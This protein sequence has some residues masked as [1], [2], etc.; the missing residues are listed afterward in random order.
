VSVKYQRIKKADEAL[1]TPLRWLTRT[2]SSITLSVTLLTFVC[3]Y[4]LFASVPIG[5]IVAGAVYLL[6]VVGGLGLGG[7]IAVQALRRELLKNTG[8]AARSVI[9]VLAVV[10]GAAASWFG[11]VAAYEAMANHPWF[12]RHSATVIYRLPGIE[13]TEL[14]FYSWWP[15]RLVLVLFVVNMVWAT[16]R[17]IE[18][19]WL[20]IGVLTVHT[21]IVVMALGS[22]FYG[23]LKVEGDTILFRQDL[24]GPIEGVFYDAVEPAIYFRYRSA[25]AMAPVPEL[26]RYNDYP[27]GEL[28]LELTSASNS[29]D[30]LGEMIRA[31]VVGYYAYADLHQHWEDADAS[32]LTPQQRNPLVEVALGTRDQAV[33]AWQEPLIA[34]VPS[35]RVLRQPDWAMEV[36]GD[37]SDR[38]LRDLM[39]DVDAPH[40]LVVELPALDDNGE[41]DLDQPPVYREAFAIQQGQTIEVPEHDLT[42]TAEAIG[43]YGI[44][45]VTPGYQGASDTRI[46]ATVTW[47]GKTF[48]RIVMHRYPERSQDFVP[49]PD[50]PS[51]GPMGERQDPDP[52][53]HLAYLDNSSTQFRLILDPDDPDKLRLLARVPGAVPLAGELPPSSRKFPLVN[54]EQGAVWMHLTR[55]IPHAVEKWEPHPVPREQRDP[56]EEG[57]F[58]HALVGVEISTTTPEG[59]PWRQTLWLPHMRYPKYPDGQNRFWP[60]SVPGIGALEV[61]F[62]RT[63]RDLPFRLQLVGFDMIPYPGS[64]IPNDYVS[65]LAVIPETQPGENR[66]RQFIQ[67]KTR[68]N[69]PLYVE[70]YKLSQVGWDPG[71]KTAPNHEATDDQ[72]RLVNQQRFS[73]IGVGNNPG[74]AMIWT[75][76]ILTSLGIPW[77]LWVKPMIV[78]RKATKLREQLQREKA[79]GDFTTEHATDAEPEQHDHTKAPEP[80]KV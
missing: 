30:F 65:T 25:M 73:I 32:G 10:I 49:R 22:I 47:Q 29:R 27:A 46:Q 21:G 19:R 18:F 38:R 66:D 78:R 70:G 14:Q 37:V 61:A 77:A 39:T 3:L 23:Q 44:P 64:D 5:M 48:N 41:P 56:K 6:I 13:M 69:D 7:Y 8:T 79:A 43:P 76:L 59:E 52:R 58:E 26:P 12:I 45:F 50:D 20:N 33:S 2:F 80:A 72:G 31:R 42:I 75:G 63:Q 1:P 74:I 55:V 71:E 15:L 67:G 28:D 53:L 4:G 24:G 62:S 40:G 36:L 11:N 16:I 34:A 17:R 68:L 60:I 57:T 54:T 9:A 35:K 51:V